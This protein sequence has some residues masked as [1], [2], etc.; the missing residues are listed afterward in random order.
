[1]TDRYRYFIVLSYDGTGFVGWQIQP[2]GRTVQ[3]TLEQ[4]LSTILRETV[5]ITG[6]GRTDTGVHA[7]YAV[8]HFDLNRSMDRT[9]RADL[10]EHLNRFLPRDIAVRGIYAV[11]SE[12]H[13]RFDA[14]SRC[15]RYYVTLSKDPFTTQY[16]TRLRGDIDFDLMNKAAE[17]MLGRHDFT[18]LSKKHTDVKTHICTVTKAK[19]IQIGVRKWCFEIEAD[20][21][22]RNMVRATVGTLLSV[23]RGKMTVEEFAAAIEAR[24]RSLAGTTAP[25]EGLFL[26]EIL[27]PF[28]LEN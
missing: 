2:T 9:T 6:A 19:W 7:R 24:D 18:T 4:G 23:G 10:V 28:R 13:A 14:V 3:G 21:F 22:L 17:S 12:A 8:A 5:S 16:E 27:Y 25:A 15:Y 1:M 20:R 26:E 11:G